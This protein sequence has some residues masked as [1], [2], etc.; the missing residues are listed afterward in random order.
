MERYARDKH[1][2]LFGIFVN[3]DDDKKV[4]MQLIIGAHVI[5]IFSV[6]N[7]VPIE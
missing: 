4:Y 3:D 1:S 7:D 5:K 2:S 6:A